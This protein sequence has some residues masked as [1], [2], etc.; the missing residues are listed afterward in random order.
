MQRAGVQLL[1]QHDFLSVFQC[2]HLFERSRIAH[3]I[4]TARQMI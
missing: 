3:G 2:V 1:P 4:V